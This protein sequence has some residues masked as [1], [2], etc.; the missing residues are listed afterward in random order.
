MHVPSEEPPKHLSLHGHA[1]LVTEQP[2]RPGEGLYH[3]QAPTSS[4]FGVFTTLWLHQMK[5][6]ARKENTFFSHPA[7]MFSLWP[8]FRHIHHPMLRLVFLRAE[9]HEGARCL[10]KRALSSSS[11]FLWKLLSKE[12]LEN[13]AV[14]ALAAVYSSSRFCFT[15]FFWLRFI[16][17]SN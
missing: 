13:R 7:E 1:L 11:G 16:G 8:N 10:N 17:L 3:K 12:Q 2:W 9:D 15:D 4:T 6:L 5:F 14:K